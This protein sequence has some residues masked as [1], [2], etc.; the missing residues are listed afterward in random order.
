MKFSFEKLTFPLFVG[1]STNLCGLL[2]PSKSAEDI[3]AIQD[4]FKEAYEYKLEHEITGHCLC[5]G[6]KNKTDLPIEIVKEDNTFFLTRSED[7]AFKHHPACT[8][9][10]WQILYGARA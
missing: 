2:V 4:I 10:E 3:K 9:H 6:D 5:Q 7:T 1:I 8:L